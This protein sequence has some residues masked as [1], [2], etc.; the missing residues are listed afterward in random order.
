M[1]TE[2]KRMGVID[3]LSAGFAL[4]LRRWWIVAIPIALN[5]F[6]WLG[7]QISARPVFQLVLNSINLPVTATP[8]IDGIDSSDGFDLFRKTLET[9]G[10]HFNMLEFLGVAMPGVLTVQSNAVDPA[11]APPPALLISDAPSF[12]VWILALTLAGFFLVALYWEGLTRGVRVHTKPVVHSYLNFVALLALLLAFGGMLTVPVMLLA[13]WVAPANPAI[14]SFLVLL[15]FL[16][17][18]WVMLYLSFALPAI[19]V[20]GANAIEA[21]AHSIAIFRFNF[22]SALGLVFVSYLIQAGF[23]VIWEELGIQPWGMLVDL[24]ANAFIASGLVAAL[25]LFYHDRVT[26]L[27]PAR[28]PARSSVKG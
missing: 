1:Q 15:V 5:V 9:S 26:A 24:I 12:L 16:L 22:S 3:A 11:S 10:D 7:P 28:P 8:S 19:F 27:A 18:L 4:V 2:T 6:L 17:I 13:A 20:S 23:G 25:M 14:G 21:I